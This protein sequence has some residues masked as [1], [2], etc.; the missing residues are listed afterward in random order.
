MN[1]SVQSPREFCFEVIFASGSKAIDE[2]DPHRLHAADVGWFG[3]RNH[4]DDEASS[5]EARFF[6]TRKDDDQ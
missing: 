2:G 1:S 4:R 6:R 5:E 3:V